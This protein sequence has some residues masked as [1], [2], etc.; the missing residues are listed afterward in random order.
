MSNRYAQSFQNGSYGDLGQ[1]DDR[2][3]RKARQAGAEAAVSS[4]LNMLRASVASGVDSLVTVGMRVWFQKELV[5][6][7]PVA[8]LP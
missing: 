2:R 8:V 3:S 1:P 5:V 7:I 6:D 4:Q